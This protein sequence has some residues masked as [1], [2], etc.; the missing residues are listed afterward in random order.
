MWRNSMFLV[1][2]YSR[3]Q[4]RD[5]AI[6]LAVRWAE[7]MGGAFLYRDA[8][9]VSSALAGAAAGLVKSSKRQGLSA[10]FQDTEP[11]LNARLGPI[12]SRRRSPRSRRR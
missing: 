9:Y 7:T 4:P 5:C 10:T 2:R 6:H 12:R 8:R 1:R 3:D 11:I